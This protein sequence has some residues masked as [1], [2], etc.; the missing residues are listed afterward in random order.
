MYKSFREGHILKLLKN[1]DSRFHQNV[2][3]DVCVNQYVREHKSL[4]SKDRNEITNSG[5]SLRR[6]FSNIVY[7]MIRNKGLL[8]SYICKQRGLA[9]PT[10]NPPDAPSRSLLRLNATTL[11]NQQVLNSIKSSTVQFNQQS[12]GLVTHTV[13]SN[14]CNSHNYRIQGPLF[15]SMTRL[16]WI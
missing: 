16:K 7:D 1:F 10:L 3:L 6:F 9:I 11:P 8:E 12:F 15:D 4:G 2:P 14:I 13:I 5:R